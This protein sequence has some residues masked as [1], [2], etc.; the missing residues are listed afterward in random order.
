MDPLYSQETKHPQQTFLFTRHPQ[1]STRIQPLKIWQ[2]SK[3]PPRVCRHPVF[4]SKWKIIPQLPSIMIHQP[5]NYLRC[6]AMQVQ[7]I[8]PSIANI[9]II[10]QCITEQRYF[11]DLNIFNAAHSNKMDNVSSTQDYLSQ[12]SRQRRLLCLISAV[13]FCQIFYELH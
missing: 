10:V 7:I 5:K 13:K 1:Q 9:S 11:I 8:Y 3:P 12:K 2:P 4:G 6:K